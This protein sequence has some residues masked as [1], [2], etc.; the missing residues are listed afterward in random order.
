LRIGISARDDQNVIPMRVAI[1]DDACNL[2]PLEQK[3]VY[4]LKNPLPTKVG[5]HL[6]EAHDP[7][8]L[9]REGARSR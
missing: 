3:R 9:T 8:L 5:W 4:D 7:E 1:C 2:H 6:L